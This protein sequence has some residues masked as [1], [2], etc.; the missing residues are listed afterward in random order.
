M[1]NS[2]QLLYIQS[3]LSTMNK[4]TIES[5]AVSAI[6]DAVDNYIIETQK[7]TLKQH[8]INQKNIN[9]SHVTEKKQ[10]YIDPNH[11]ESDYSEY[12]DNDEGLWYSDSDYTT[13]D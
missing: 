2:G 13:D 8:A 11:S 12:D 6:R 5:G 9:L 7:N 3:T 1:I 4:Y 10:L